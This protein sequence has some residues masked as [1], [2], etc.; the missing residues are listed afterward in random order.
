ML[1]EIIERKTARNI[2]PGLEKDGHFSKNTE[3]IPEHL[4]KYNENF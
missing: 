3:D 2:A 1:Q 4:D